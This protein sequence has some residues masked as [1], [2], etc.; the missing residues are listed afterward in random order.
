[1]NDKAT[2]EI[3]KELIWVILLRAFFEATTIFCVLGFKS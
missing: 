3:R 2:K 1:M